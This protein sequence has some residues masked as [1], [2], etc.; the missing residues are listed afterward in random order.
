MC[1]QNQNI[2]RQVFAFWKPFWHPVHFLK[3]GLWRGS[4][5]WQDSFWQYWNKLIG[6][7][8]HG[9]RHIT[10]FKEGDGCSRNEAH[11]YCYNCQRCI[12]YKETD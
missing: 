9:H 7:K 6:C 8:I 4:Y 12:D 2:W 5:F 11:W 1:R 3:F 10:Y